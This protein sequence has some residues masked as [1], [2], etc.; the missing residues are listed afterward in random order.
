M[1][2]LDSH[3]NTCV[4]GSSALIIQD[5]G[6]P[7]NVLSCNPAL[8]NRT[9]Q[10]LS[11]VIVYYRPITAQTYHMV[12]RQLI[13]IPHIEHHLLCP[14]QSCVNDVTI[15]EIPKFLASNPTN[16]THSIIVT[17]PDDPAQQLV[18]PLAICGV[19]THLPTQPIK[20]E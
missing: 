3:A 17:D 1:L 19:T 10:T 2:E 8:V 9:Y 11:G 6:R 15:N 14:I 5:H 20:K 13:S 16:E 7:I 4:L 12:I 18:F